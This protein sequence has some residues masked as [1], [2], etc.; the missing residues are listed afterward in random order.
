[1]KELVFP[2]FYQHD[3]VPWVI[4][5]QNAFTDY[6]R[7]DPVERK[8]ADDRDLFYDVVDDYHHIS[9]DEAKA[10]ING[11]PEGLS[12]LNDEEIYEKLSSVFADK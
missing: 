6:E 9:E 10:I 2:I 4:V 5:R 7:F 12:G 11:I 3:D 1:M 8:W